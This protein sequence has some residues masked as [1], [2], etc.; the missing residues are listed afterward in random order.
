[1]KQSETTTVEYA[2]ITRMAPIS[3][4]D[5]SSAGHG[6]GGNVWT[7]VNDRLR[8]RWVWVL[9]FGA[10][11][12]TIL[13]VG[14][15][16][17]APVLFSS[18]GIV[19]VDPYDDPVISAVPGTETLQ[20]YQPFMQ[21]QAGLI[22]SDRVISIAVQQLRDKGYTEMNSLGAAAEFA[23]NLDVASGRN[24]FLISVEYAS[25]DPKFS[26]D[27]VNAILDAY[28]SIDP[29][30]EKYSEKLQRMLGLKKTQ[31]TEIT[32]LE[33][34]RRRYVEASTFANGMQETERFLVDESIG[35]KTQLAQMERQLNLNGPNADGDMPGFGQPTDADLDEIDPTLR[36]VRMQL[37]QQRFEYQ[38]ASTRLGP[39]SRSL[40]NMERALAEGEA[41]LVQKIEDA[42]AIWLAQRNMAGTGSLEEQIEWTKQKLASTEKALSD[43]RREKNTVAGYDKSIADAYDQLA[44]FNKTIEQYQAEE[45]QIRKGRISIFSRPS[46][47]EVPS[48]DRR[49]P[50]A[51]AGF[52]T[53]LALPLMAFFLLGTLDRRAY[54]TAQLLNV[55]EFDCLGVLPDMSAVDSEDPETRDLANQCVHRIRNRIELIRKPGAGFVATVTSPAQGDGKTSLAIALGWSY[56]ASGYRTILVDCDF[57][58]RSLSLQTD[59]L[60][61]FG[62][63]EVIRS[64]KLNGEVT[65]M[66][67]KNLSVLGI[68]RDPTVG[69]ESVRRVDF[70][71]LFDLL[72]EQFEIIIV[73]TGPMLASVEALPITACADGVILAFRRGRSQRRL[74]ECV[75][76]LRNTRNYLGVVFNCASQ[77][78]CVRYSSVSRMSKEVEDFDDEIASGVRPRESRPTPVVKNSLVKALE[79]QPTAEEK[80]THE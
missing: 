7:L 68:G 1:M 63:K 25:T 26:M 37:N 78:E 22:Q 38:Q 46:L 13:A 50:L 15:Y 27:A 14:G 18:R 53:G 80:M 29:A 21:S 61:S 57:V 23:S 56:A 69:P 51:A 79:H 62:V 30:D 60:G 44:V 2:P 35:Y 76:E 41:F 74:A 49:I 9:L 39:T 32:Y 43:L 31:E 36:S 16:M 59:Q 24:S 5:D 48:T 67:H 54:A 65:A 10:V 34:E 70:E 71:R 77:S 6:Q 45:S 64:Q 52:A 3:G 55:D 19:K 75:N 66:G 12:S 20:M 40:K 47:S 11:L 33:E 42:R 72:R 28:T 58:G 17:L 4:F 73:D 8:G